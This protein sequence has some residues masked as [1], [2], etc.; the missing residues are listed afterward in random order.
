METTRNL[1]Q[2]HGSTIEKMLSASPVCPLKPNLVVYTTRLDDMIVF[3]ND[4]SKTTIVD[5]LQKIEQESKPTLP[6][7]PK[8]QVF[9]NNRLA[10][11]LHLKKKIITLNKN[12]HAVK[13]FKER[14]ITDE[15]HAESVALGNSVGDF[16]QNNTI[17][18]S[19]TF[20]TSE[21]NRRLPTSEDKRIDP[22]VWPV[23]TKVDYENT[24]N[25]CMVK[26]RFETDLYILDDDG[27]IIRHEKK[28]SQKM[29]M[30]EINLVVNYC[31][32]F[33]REQIVAHLSKRLKPTTL[34]RIKNAHTCIPGQCKC[35]CKPNSNN[36]CMFSIDDYID[37]TDND[38]KEPTKEPETNSDFDDLLKKM[39]VSKKCPDDY[40]LQNLPN[41]TNVPTV[42]TSKVS[43]LNENNQYNCY[44]TD[45]NGEVIQ[46]QTHCKGNFDT[47]DSYYGKVCCW[48]ARENIIKKLIK[49]QKPE[50]I[51]TRIKEKHLCPSDKCTCCCKTL[52]PA[53][54]RRIGNA[55]NCVPGQSKGEP[56]NS[57][58][59]FSD[60][61]I[62]LTDNDLENN[63]K[64]PIKEPEESISFDEILKKMLVSKRYADDYLLKKLSN[65]KDVNVSGPKTSKVSFLNENNQYNH[66]ETD[67]NGE[68]IQSLTFEGGD[69]E[70]KDSYYGKVCCWYARENI[71]KKLKEEQKPASILTCIKKKHFCSI[72]KCTCC[73]KPEELILPENSLH[74]GKCVAEPVTKKRRILKNTPSFKTKH[75][76]E[77]NREK[78]KKTIDIENENKTI[79]IKVEIIDIDNDENK[80]IVND[81]EK[82]STAAED[83]NKTMDIKVEIINIEDDNKT[84]HIEDENKAVDVKDEIL[85]P[86][87]EDATDIES[88]RKTINIED[89]IKTNDIVDK[90]IDT[91]DEIGAFLINEN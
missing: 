53:N 51:L 46:S 50:S 26:K 79:D 39:L 10:S 75:G 60:D 3:S 22:V 16:T 64:E 1:K 68:V 59:V 35:C 18:K 27:N 90:P 61:Y 65:N 52:N 13:R 38:V 8:M 70:T 29:N 20:K 78:E 14:N 31:C 33:N 58:A 74:S 25:L 45:I 24:S 34:R 11:Y 19:T 57:V 89:D 44:E 15:I 80:I 56:N 55:D 85:A 84:I 69:F 40:L 17:L 76:I 66:Y 47:E 37:P 87:T 28:K 71:I 62:D 48:Y 49:E 36:Y 2:Q 23:T 5:A 81:N 41:D 42:K 73:C 82:K 83:K 86:D 91:E 30:Q 72:D 7:K 6:K 43:F 67:I 9:R 54:L 88:G 21:N 12:K 63:V 77:Q 4:T 32:W